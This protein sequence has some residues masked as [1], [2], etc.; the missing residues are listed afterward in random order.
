MGTSASSSAAAWSRVGRVVATRAVRVPPG[1]ELFE[2]RD[3]P[4]NA[5]PLAPRRGWNHSEV[6][7]PAK[8]SFKWSSVRF[9]MRARLRSRP[10][11]RKL[12]R[13]AQLRQVCGFVVCRGPQVGREA[14]SERPP[15]RGK[16]RR[17]A[18]SVLA[19][20]AGD[21]AECHGAIPAG[22]QGQMR[23]SQG[24]TGTGTSLRGRR[25]IG[26]TADRDDRKTEYRSVERRFVYSGQ[27]RGSTS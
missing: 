25:S 1:F 18:A 14:R 22:E 8:Y 6:S 10:M 26:A 12:L 3:R 17:P 15:L 2:I 4:P 5:N 9:R 23:S 13:N 21:V 20:D 24:K 11:R 16:C 19:D 7:T 27:M